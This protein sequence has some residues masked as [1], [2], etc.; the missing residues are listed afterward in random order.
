MAL[1][2][3]RHKEDNPRLQEVKRPKFMFPNAIIYFSNAIN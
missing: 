3:P 2:F 1:R